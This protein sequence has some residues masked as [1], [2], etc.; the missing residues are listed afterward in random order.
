[1]SSLYD[2][3]FTST[4]RNFASTTNNT[5]KTLVCI[6]VFKEIEGVL[7]QHSIIIDVVVVVAAVVPS[8]R[9]DRLLWFWQRS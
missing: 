8:F 9:F 3:S 7:P 6:S 1:M 2:C 4:H 5:Y